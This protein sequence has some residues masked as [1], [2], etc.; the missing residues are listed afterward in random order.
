MSVDFASAI[1]A[2]DA[3][4][5]DLGIERAGEQAAGAATKTNGPSFAEMVGDGLQSAIDSS[6]HAETMTMQA[7]TGEA[8]IADVVSAVTNAEVM[9]QTVVSVRDKV[10]QAYQEVLRMP[11]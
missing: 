7:I 2:Y 1:K 8:D 9:L 5:R 6:R 3:T 10:L 11:I 4:L